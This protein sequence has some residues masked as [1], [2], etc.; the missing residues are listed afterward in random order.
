MAA[1]EYQ[2]SAYRALTDQERAE[3]ATTSGGEPI[4]EFGDGS[5][6]FVDYVRSDVLLSL[7]GLR[8]KAPTEPAFLIATQVMELL[9]KLGH[10][11]VLHVRD[12]LDADDVDAALWALRRVRAVQHQLVGAWELLSSLSPA[13]Y[14][15]F[16]DQL[17]DGSGFQS[18]VYRQWEFALGNKNAALARPYAGNPVTHGELLRALNEPSLYDA[19]L[20]LLA[21][22]GMPL[23]AEVLDRDWAEPYQA[24]PEV[25]RAWRRV[26]EDPVRHQA[27][28]RLAEALV[29]VAYEFGRWRATHVLVVERVLGGKPGTGGTSGVEWLRRVADHRFFPELWSVR[30]AL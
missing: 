12:R 6:P 14:R 16:R 30:G 25:E 21:R 22:N 23:P 26:Y 27:L 19:A 7:Q 28:H 2:R 20:R 17:G 15:E 4:L 29:D 11:E 13:D 18:F 8:T 10:I 3:R 1:K 9:F 24:R 5:T